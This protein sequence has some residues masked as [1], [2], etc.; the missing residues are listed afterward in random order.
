MTDTFPVKPDIE[1][2]TYRHYKGGLYEVTDLSCDEETHEWRV[3]YVPLYDVEPG[4]PD[5][6]N[7]RSSVFFQEIAV[8]G[9]IKRRFEKT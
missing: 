5:K 2:G 6:W 8:D 9:I 4:T 3:T 7:R 1:F